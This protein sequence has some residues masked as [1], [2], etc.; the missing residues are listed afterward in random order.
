ARDR[1]RRTR[2]SSF[3]RAVAVLAEHARLSR[4][5]EAT[6]LDGRAVPLDLPLHP[7]RVLDELHRQAQQ[8]RDTEPPQHHP[9]LEVRGVS[10]RLRRPDLAAAIPAGTPRPWT[11]S[12]T[13][14]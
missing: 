9:V 1:A 2:A 6:P 13:R 12:A 11:G 14:P 4:T 8:A 10:G 3:P 7:Q 5:A